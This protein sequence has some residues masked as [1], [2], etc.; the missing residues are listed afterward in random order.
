[1]KKNHT[2]FKVFLSAASILSMIE[3]G[4]SIS[5]FE[6][7]QSGDVARIRTI[8]E[9]RGFKPE[10]L[11]L[12]D[13]RGN[14]ALHL[15]VESK[16]D[17]EK[18][19][20]VI[21]DL[22]NG[23]ADINAV[24]GY[25][26]TPLFLAVSL[27]RVDYAVLLI[28]YGAKINVTVKRVVG[29]TVEE[30]ERS[31]VSYVPTSP[32]ANGMAML[33]SLTD[34]GADV[35]VSDKYGSTLLCRAA[36]AG[37]TEMVIFLLTDFKLNVNE[38]T[39]SG[40]TPLWLAI[41]PMRNTPP[42]NMEMVELLVERFK[43]NVNEYDE[44]EGV[45]DPSLL[46]SFI[47]VLRFG[48]KKEEVVAEKNAI[49]YLLDHG[50]NVNVRNGEGKTPL[51]VLI[52]DRLSQIISPYGF[53][54]ESH[55]QDAWLA[56][57]DIARLLLKYEADV[58]IP[59]ANGITLLE[60][61]VSKTRWLSAIP[62]QIKD[63]IKLLA[64]L[65]AN[66]NLFLKG[67]PGDG[68]FY[69]PLHV[70]RLDMLRFA[71]EECGAD[72]NA[73]DSAEETLS[74]CAAKSN[75]MERLKYLVERRADLC[76]P[77][78]FGE[79]PLS[80]V[81]KSGDLLTVQFLLDHGADPRES[82]RRFTN[83]LHSAVRSGKKEVV[84]F[85]L[86]ISDMNVNSRDLNGWTA[87]HYAESVDIAE[88][89]L[90]RGANI[91][92]IAEMLDENLKK[93]YREP[94]GTPI[95]LAAEDGNEALVAFYI[96]RGADATLADKPKRIPL[97]KAVKNGK[98]GVARVLIS[99]LPTDIDAITGTGETLLTL[100]VREKR[101]EMVS[102][103][104][105]E[106]KAN[107]HVANRK[108]ETPF[109]IVIENSNDFVYSGEK[110][111][112]LDFLLAHGADINGLSCGRTA[113]H[114]AMVSGKM[115]LVGDL[116]KIYKADPN[117]FSEGKSLWHIAV[118]E[119]ESTYISYS[120]YISYSL[121]PANINVLVDGKTPLDLAISLEKKRWIWSLKWD[122]AKTSSE[123]EAEGLR[124]LEAEGSSNP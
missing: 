30:F 7:V 69:T 118:A 53:P 113:L 71:V 2:N 15:A 19:I 32:D 43:A 66:F 37:H 9:S 70:I 28:E 87:L 48:L 61:I 92:E 40:C 80:H 104:V 85:F 60:Q 57:E 58:N 55:L 78:I 64:D 46:H 101:M 88:S 25:E 93:F 47:S 96:G 76:R 45:E 22:L 89:L 103:L 63:T 50:A 124:A 49:E 67:A 11:N 86:D 56:K 18:T 6:A 8:K 20:R 95:C 77:N 54:Q 52:E 17:S 109:G 33:R 82:G 99:H 120:F 94:F 79:T 35:N 65:G 74:C 72:V 107:V 83:V 123:L 116:L 44:R 62:S 105:E 122:G 42:R 26:L 75:N 10:T 5:L 115:Y 98:V 73:I 111:V 84:D 3:P 13:S 100:A 29:N 31:A 121:K 16:V 34:R 27:N 106:H 114:S 14:T 23:G 1:M 117:V 112:M 119:L 12:R 38:R 90:S 41:T 91:N 68:I 36:G 59:N 102:F 81:A 97:I 39:R 21:E 51:Y 4:N 24:N 110:R 108:G